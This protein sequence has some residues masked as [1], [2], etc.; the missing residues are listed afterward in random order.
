[1]SKQ[2]AAWA[3]AVVAVGAIVWIASGAIWGLIAA[4]AT[5]LLSE[6]V[7]RTMRMRRRAARGDTSSPSVTDA[8]KSRRKR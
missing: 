2:N 8:V 3:A 6:V 4:A 1:M 7:Q 5:L